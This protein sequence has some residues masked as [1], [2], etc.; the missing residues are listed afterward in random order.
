VV[1]PTY[2][3]VCLLLSIY[4]ISDVSLTMIAWGPAKIEYHL[5]MKTDK[6][7]ASFTNTSNLSGSGLGKA[8]KNTAVPV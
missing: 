7:H 6:T 8:S 3:V 4:T 5:H 2:N 1:C